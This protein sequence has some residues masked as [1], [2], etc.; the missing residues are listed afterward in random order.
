M[1]NKISWA[2]DY[3]SYCDLGLEKEVMR[4]EDGIRTTGDKNSFEWWYFDA[5]YENGF[6]IVVIFYTKNRFDFT[7]NANPTV[8]IDITLPN[9]QV[10]CNYTSEGYGQ[11]IRAAKENCDVK[12]NDC[13]ISFKDNQYS[14]YYKNDEIEYKCNM[15]VELN[16]YRPNTGHIFFN[17]NKK[18]YFA[19][20]VAA[21]KAK[22][23]GTLKIK[24]ILWNLK[25]IGYHDHNWG[26]IKM[27]KY[28][29]NWYWCRA[30]V[31][32]YTIVANDIITEKENDF[33]RIPSIYI[34]KD[35]EILEEDY[36]NTII[37]R[38]RTIQHP[39]SCK[40]IDNK[41]IFIQ[42]GKD[43]TNYIIEFERDHDIFASSLL[44]VMGKSNIQLFF[45]LIKKSNPTYLRC[46]GIVRLTVEED[47]KKTIYES[48]AI[49]EQMFF[50]KNKK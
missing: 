22:A 14:V 19:W 16:M 32:P 30:N 42:K 24:G 43:N 49:W 13:N 38:E 7:G 29:N 11:R 48:E 17:E 26:T 4:W 10:I 3:K 15:E 20:M 47:N 37:K 50:G 46:V 35:G 6:K 8:S 45:D 21:P 28:I 2:E 12:I 23:K 36:S 40:T 41:I 5:E 33:S 1:N 39:L 18:D 44:R 34:A 9:G 27:D 31:G 25:G